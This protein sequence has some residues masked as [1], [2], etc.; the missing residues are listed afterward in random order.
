MTDTSGI[1]VLPYSR[2]VGQDDVKLALELNYVAPDIGGVLITGQPGTAKS[3]VVRAFSLMIRDRLPVTLPIDATDDRV[4]G[5]WDLDAL[6]RGLTEEKPGLLEAAH[7]DGLLYIDE[8]NLLSDHVVNIIL[9]VASTGQLSVQREGI[10]KK[11]RLRF[12]LVGTMNPEEGGLRPQLLDRFGLIAVAGPLSA[13]DRLAML[14]AV[15]RF[16]EEGYAQE[17]G[18]APDADGWIAEGQALDRASRERLE[19][20]RERLFEVEV[21]EDVMAR[22]IRIAAE[23]KAVGHRGDVVLARA[24]RAMAALRGAAR[25]EPTHV[26][27][28]AAMALQHR[29]PESA[30]GS[31]AEW[32][33]SDLAVLDDALS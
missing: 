14:R 19:H 26:R 1:T 3:T 11:K 16:D 6:M 22:C 29:R 30:F 31:S 32:S 7:D 5:G 27:E 8:V 28:I 21:P 12:A 23:L 24:A 10:D 4:L 13:N 20:A 33:E 9:D 17:S 25:V 2:V 18:A 15:L